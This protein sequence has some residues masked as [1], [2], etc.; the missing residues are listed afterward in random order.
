MN[1]PHCDFKFRV[2]AINGN[3]MPEMAPLVCESC[4]EVSLYE[5][6]TVRKLT[7]VE[8]D[9]VKRS[10]AYCDVIAPAIEVI[11]RAKKAQNAI[12]NRFR[13]LAPKPDSEQNTSRGLVARST[14]NPRPRRSSMPARVPSMTTGLKPTCAQPSA[15]AIIH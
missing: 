10:P 13:P 12:T 3:Q 14:S 5:S 4:S 8:L 11:R 6:G 7:P 9:Y 1:C 2:L 15:S